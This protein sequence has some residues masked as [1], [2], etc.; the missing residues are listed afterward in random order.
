MV[1]RVLYLIDDD[2]SARVATT[3]LLD[4]NG[5]SVT[6]FESAEAF[7]QNVNTPRGTVIADVQLPGISGLQLLR[8]LTARECAVSIV[9]MSAQA[10]DALAAEAMNAGAVSLLL[11]PVHPGRLMEIIEQCVGRDA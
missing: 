5:Y 9:L 11:K 2:E 7:L 8:K 6:A 3:L 10:D 4:V 1:D